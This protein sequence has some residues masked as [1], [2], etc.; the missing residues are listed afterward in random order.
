[1][2]TIV[3]LG[4]RGAGKSTVAREL[5][6]MLGREAVDLDAAIVERAGKPIPRIFAEDGEETFRRLESEALDAAL[7]RRCILAPGG[8]A[9]L[10]DRNRDAIRCSKAFAVYLRAKPET[11]A[12]RVE[13]D[14]ENVRPPLVPGGP[15]AE[16][17]AL[18]AVRGPLYEELAHLTIETDALDAAAVS[19]KIRA[20]L[21]SPPS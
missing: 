21:E 7:A 3:L 10:R 16:A 12:A 4:L 6:R 14:R 5:A 15:L 20:A 1:V 13:A 8:G 9:V 11:L 18:L 17:R 2:R 19:E